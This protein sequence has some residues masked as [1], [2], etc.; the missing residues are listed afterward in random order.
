M[1][2]V[3]QYVLVELNMQIYQYSAEWCVLLIVNMKGMR[4]G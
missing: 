1:N 2:A 3:N 4:Y